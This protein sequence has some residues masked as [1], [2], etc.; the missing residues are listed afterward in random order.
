MHAYARMT[1]RRRRF[2]CTQA[3]LPIES[4][5]HLGVMTRFW[6]Q[7]HLVAFPLMGV[8]VAHALRRLLPRRLAGS[9]SPYPTP[10]RNPK[11]GVSNWGCCE[12]DSR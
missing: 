10:D 4:A 5:L 1:R 11:Q 3:N 9:S 7:S 6:L 2:V 12:S 8:T